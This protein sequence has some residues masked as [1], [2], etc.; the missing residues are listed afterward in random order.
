MKIQTVFFFGFFNPFFKKPMHWV[1]RVAVEPKFCS[2]RRAARNGLF[3]KRARHERN[4]V[5]KH[6]R[7]RHALNE[8]CRRF[9]ASAEEIKAILPSRKRN[10]NEILR[11][12]FADFKAKLAKNGQKGSDNIPFERGDCFS[13][14]G[15]RTIRKAVC[16]P[17]NE[18]KRHTGCFSASYRSVTDYSVSV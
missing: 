5:K 1:F 13:A 17:R 6:T 2:R 7:Q 10:V 4:L 16:C 8:R 9:V 12:F 11:I 3:N 15:K 18:R 14:K